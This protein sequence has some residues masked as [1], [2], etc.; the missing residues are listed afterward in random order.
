MGVTIGDVEGL[1]TGAL[2]GIFDTGMLLWAAVG[3]ATG[4]ADDPIEGSLVGLKV[5][6]ATGV[7]EGLA[8]GTADGDLVGEKTGTLEGFKDCGK[9]DGLRHSPDCC[10]GC[11]H[12]L[13][14]APLQDD[15]GSQHWESSQHWPAKFDTQFVVA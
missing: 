8:T 14:E 11:W 1:G 6:V 7:H 9:P 5:G 12:C 4:V 13:N 2:V 15:P 3:I 10:G